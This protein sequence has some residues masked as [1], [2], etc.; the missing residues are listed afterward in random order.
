VYRAAIT[1]AAF[2]ITVLAVM[3]RS[4]RVTVPFKT[5]ETKTLAWS[6]WSSMV[7]SHGPSSF[8]VKG[9]GPFLPGPAAYLLVDEAL[10]H[11]QIAK[12]ARR[13]HR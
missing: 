11:R 5:L 10:R 13:Q 9:E 12:I 7:K 2:T 3:V 4:R 6:N 1:V 8:V